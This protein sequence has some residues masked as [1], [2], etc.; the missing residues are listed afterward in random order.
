[1][2]ATPADD[3]GET[4]SQAGGAAERSDRKLKSGVGGDCY[5]RNGPCD[6]YTT[7]VA[8]GQVWP[9]ISARQF[10]RCVCVTD[11]C[12]WDEVSELAERS[13]RQFALKRMLAL[14]P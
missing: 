8:G 9:E 12:D 4:L 14:L 10:A 7:N 5:S 13:Y 2:F 11:E 6:I 3:W 1:M